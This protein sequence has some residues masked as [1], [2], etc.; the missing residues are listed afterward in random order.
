MNEID[1]LS[2]YNRTAHG[3]G[4]RAYD[5]KLNPGTNKSPEDTGYVKDRH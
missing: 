4:N 2:I 5:D 3:R 1:V